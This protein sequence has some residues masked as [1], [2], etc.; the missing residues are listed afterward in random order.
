[1]EEVKCLH[2]R[3]LSVGF[4][5][6]AFLSLFQRIR[7]LVICPTVNIGQHVTFLSGAE[8]KEILILT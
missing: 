1:M 4:V 2:I 8:E 6:Y 7:E 3:G 5:M